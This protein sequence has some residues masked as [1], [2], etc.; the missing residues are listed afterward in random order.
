MKRTRTNNEGHYDS[1]RASVNYRT[2][3]EDSIQN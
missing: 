3:P 1:N 2:L